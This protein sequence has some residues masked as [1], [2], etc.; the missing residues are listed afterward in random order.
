MYIFHKIDFLERHAA[1]KLPK[2]HPN[3][4]VIH[5]QN[6]KGQNPVIVGGSDT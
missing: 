1:L 5:I 4:T 3:H 2:T 6:V